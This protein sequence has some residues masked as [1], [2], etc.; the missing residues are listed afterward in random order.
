MS[1]NPKL[2]RQDKQR[3]NQ[4]LDDL[5]ALIARRTRRLNA[6]EEAARAF[7]SVTPFDPRTQPVPD[8]RRRVDKQ[9]TPFAFGSQPSRLGETMIEEF[10][11]L[12]RRLRGESK[13]KR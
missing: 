6:T 7:D 8:G 2:D 9:G 5:D 12:G 3:L 1:K 13:R 10:D 11:A 4:L